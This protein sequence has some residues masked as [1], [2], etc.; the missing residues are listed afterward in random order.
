MEENK[1]TKQGLTNAFETLFKGIKE[2]NNKEATETELFNFLEKQK[3]WMDNP[4]HFNLFVTNKFEDIVDVLVENTFSYVD[5][6]MKGIYFYYSIYE[7]MIRRLIET[8][9]G[10][11]CC[12]DKSRFILKSYFTYCREG[13]LPE[14]STENYWVPNK[15][16]NDSWIGLVKG[17]TELVYGG[18][19]TNYLIR[20]REII[21][22]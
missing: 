4:E 5:D 6:T 10:S 14:Y 20:M 16:S 15:G 11:G 13:K 3:Q 12:A 22:A 17:I 8:Q 2:R 1:V 21:E 9:E 19:P 18:N 7:S